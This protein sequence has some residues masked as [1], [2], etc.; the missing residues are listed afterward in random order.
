MTMGSVE[1]PASPEFIINVNRNANIN[2]PGGEPL[3]NRVGGSGPQSNV[4]INVR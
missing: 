1:F 4:T 2:V 3:A